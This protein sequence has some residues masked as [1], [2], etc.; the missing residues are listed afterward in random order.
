M[1]NFIGRQLTGNIKNNSFTSV[2]ANCKNIELTSS[3]LN[4]LNNYFSCPNVN[5]YNY[6]S[7]TK[8]APIDESSTDAGLVWVGGKNKIYSTGNSNIYF[9][10][11]NAE[12]N[13]GENCFSKIS[14]STIDYMFGAVNV[15]T[16]PYYFMQNNDFNGTNYPSP[17]LF[18]LV[19]YNSQ[20]DIIPYFGGSNFIC[21]NTTTSG[22]IW[23]IRDLGNGIMDTIYRTPNTSGIPQTPE[24]YLYSQSYQENSF[25][26]YYEAILHLKA[27]I[28]DYPNSSYVNTAL[29]DLYINYQALDTSGNQ[30]TRDILNSDLKYYLDNRIL[31][32]SY[33]DEFNYNAYNITL[34]CLDNMKEYLDAKAGYEFIALYHPE[35]FIKL[36][37][38]WDYAEIESI[39][40]GSGGISSNEEKMTDNEYLNFVIKR[41]NALINEDPVKQKVKNSFKNTKKQVEANLEK[42]IK[43]K[44]KDEKIT[45]TEISRIKSEES[46]IDSKT[47]SNIRN[48]KTLKKEEREKKTVRRFHI[49][50]D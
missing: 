4:L 46:K 15:P 6:A 50:K 23:Q 35:A 19:D 5:Y 10:G 28:N 38:S 3:I 11:G 17:N 36:M 34:M 37:A 7:Y 32:G 49:W 21:L 12:L 43:S 16:S 40:N 48:A 26:N 14:Y 20:N 1:Y 25:G 44:T 42:E 30:G 13:W 31:S 29:N 22:T 9:Y 8:L 2:S 47:I 24:Q 33:N 27:L 41:V 45:K 18:G 39:L